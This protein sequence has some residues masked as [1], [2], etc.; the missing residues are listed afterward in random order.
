MISYNDKNSS[1]DLVKMLGDSIST[2]IRQKNLLRKDVAKRANV[3]EVTLR[4]I[5]EGQNVKLDSVIRVLQV[6][7]RES[8]LT[9]LIN[10]S[11]VNPMSLYPQMVKER[12]KRM[13]I[14]QEKAEEIIVTLSDKIQRPKKE[15]RVTAVDIR[16]LCE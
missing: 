13:K 4:R 12:N 11:P 8:A 15:R 14:K 6:L 5:C 7:N 2:D 16:K 9:A 10:P 3:T 1:S